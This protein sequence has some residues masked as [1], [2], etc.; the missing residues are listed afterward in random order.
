MILHSDIGQETMVKVPEIIG[1]IVY[2]IQICGDDNEIIPIL[3]V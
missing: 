2:T 3:Q 1:D